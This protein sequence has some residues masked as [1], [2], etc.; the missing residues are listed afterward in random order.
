MQAAN[1]MTSICTGDAP[2]V[3]CPSTTVAMRALVTPN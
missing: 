2:A 3:L 1:P